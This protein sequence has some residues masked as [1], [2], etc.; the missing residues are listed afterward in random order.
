TTRTGA[1][2]PTAH[3]RAARQAW[4]AAY[5]QGAPPP[6]D[7]GRP[8]AAVGR[9]AVAGEVVSVRGLDAGCVTR[10][11]AQHLA[12]RVMNV[13]RIAAAAAAVET[14]RARATER[15]LE[16]T[17]LVADALRVALPERYDSGFDCGLFHTCDDTAR[18]R[19]V[20]ELAG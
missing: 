5:T 3:E 11:K 16:A 19:Y 15:G 13:K 7:I 20:G 17:F 18:A 12:G 10:C 4:A 9:L 1:R 14:A 8:Q 6:W 2:P